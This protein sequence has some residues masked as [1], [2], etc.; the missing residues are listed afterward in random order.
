MNVVTRNR[1]NSTTTTAAVAAM[2]VQPTNCDSC[3]YLASALSHARVNRP[4]WS[5]WFWSGLVVVR[6][7]TR[8]CGSTIIFKWLR[9]GLSRVIL[10]TTEITR[11]TYYSCHIAVP[12]YER[13]TKTALIAYGRSDLGGRWE[14]RIDLERVDGR[15]PAGC[16]PHS[17]ITTTIGPTPFN[18]WLPSVRRQLAETA[19]RNYA[20]KLSYAH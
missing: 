8:G 14:A 3:I 1:P 7:G 5:E 10:S 9:H 13:Q 6:G 2:E 4:R 17:R 16:F 20:Y 11:R 12:A 19:Q 15:I 18:Q